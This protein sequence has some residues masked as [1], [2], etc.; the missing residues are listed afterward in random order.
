ML[1][2]RW[3]CRGGISGCLIESCPHCCLLSHLGGDHPPLCTTM[4]TSCIIA[5]ATISN[6]K[7]L[8]PMSQNFLCPYFLSRIFPPLP[9][10]FVSIILCHRLP[11][12]AAAACSH[13]IQALPLTPPI[14]QLLH[15]PPPLLLSTTVV[16]LF[17]CRT[18]PPSAI[19]R[20]HQLP[21]P[22]AMLSLPTTAHCHLNMQ[23]PHPQLRWPLGSFVDEKKHPSRGG[24]HI[25][26]EKWSRE[27]NHHCQS[28]HKV[29]WIIPGLGRI[30]QKCPSRYGRQLRTRRS[31]PYSLVWD[32]YRWEP[33]WSRK[34]YHQ[35][36]NHW[37]W[38]LAWREYVYLIKAFQQHQTI[39]PSVADKVYVCSYCWGL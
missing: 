22:A 16:N 38:Q 25:C 21:L 17:Q 6:I 1:D 4:S 27:T 39:N 31:C 15:H 13:C 23:Q 36:E 5:A 24:I 14:T 3:P 33:R 30:K 26:C 18:L 29:P 28:C 10:S 12:S 9:L 37:C 35:L 19:I 11:P 8:F 20:Y 7:I 2:L 32:C 34:R